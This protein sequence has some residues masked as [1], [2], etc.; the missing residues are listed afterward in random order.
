MSSTRQNKA[1]TITND[2]VY[3]LATHQA[4]LADSLNV[5]I[6]VANVTERDS[7]AKFDGMVVCRRDLPGRPLEQW[8]G[9]GWLPTPVQT[10][11]YA[12][13]A[14][15]GFSITGNIIVEQMGAKKR[16]SVDLNLQRTGAGLSIT[17]PWVAIGAVIPSA[18]RGTAELKYAAIALTGGT[19]N[20]HA[21]ASVNPA[22][23]IL[24]VRSIGATFTWTTNAVCT[25]N[26]QYLI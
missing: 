24:S 22:D 25:L 23:G 5:V 16:V 10:G 26:F 11:V 3:D 12:S 19:N 9:A 18:G 15:T 4:R 8:D 20:N 2:E 1:V 17:D 7:L 6:P 21:T 13:P 14:I